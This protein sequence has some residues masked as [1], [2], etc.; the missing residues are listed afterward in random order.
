MVAN[1]NPLRP[2]SIIVPT[3]RE[4]RNIPILVEQVFAALARSGR[5]GEMILV[6]DNSDDGTERVVG[7]LAKTY[8]VRLIVRRTERGLSSA[9]VRGF[10]EAKN[11]LLLCMDADLSH[12]PES[13]PNV[14]AA[15][16]SG[17]ADFCIGSRYVSGGRTKEDWGF[18]RKLN[19][20]G[21][22]LLA[23]PLTRAKDP[24]A[25]F[26]CISREVFENA[27]TAGLNAIGYKIGLEIMIKARCRRVVE[28]P[29]VF[30]DRLHGESKLTIRQQLLYLQHLCS[31]YWFRRPVLLVVF[32]LLAAAAMISL[33]TWI[34]SSVS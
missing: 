3:F 6:D 8:P 21:A 7:E 10:E 14:I 22:T 25:G 1:V 5:A 17:E 33:G 31:L 12:P 15:I 30:A 24:M 2:V 27:R 28:T 29:I 34:V 16:D 32:G 13:V 20:W 26:F 9:V 4:A 18:L 11:D 19:S 23:R